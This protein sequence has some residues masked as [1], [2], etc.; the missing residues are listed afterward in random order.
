MYS[1]GLH[2]KDDQMI[3]VALN[4]GW[5]ET[6]LEGYE[7]LPLRDLKGEDRDEAITFNLERFLTR[8]KGGRDNLFI[9][10]SRDKVLV[11]YVYLPLAVEEN[12]RAALGYEM[13]RLTPFPA[14][15]V[16][17]D[18]Y[19]LKRLPAKNLLYL[20]LITVKKEVLDYYFNLLKKIGIRPRG[21]EISSTALF[22]SYKKDRSGAEKLLTTEWIQ[23]SRLMTLARNT[24]PQ[25]FPQPLK[26]SSTEEDQP[27]AVD[28]LIGY[29]NSHFELNIIS[30]GTL[31]YSRSLPVH[32]ADPGAAKD[33]HL[34][35]HLQEI[36]REVQ[37]GMLN[38][39]E[40]KNQELRIRF[41]LAGREMDDDY[42]K[43]CTELSSLDCSVMKDFAIT[44]DDATPR[45]MLPLLSVA[46]GLAL[47]GLRRVP[48]DINLI[49]AAL[50]PKRK[51]SKKKMAAF[52]FA[53]FLLFLAGGFIV[54]T[55]I[56][57]RAH[58]AELDLQLAELKL[59]AKAV[60]AMQ[61]EANKTEKYAVDLNQIKE[62]DISKLRILEELTR[63]IP[64][65]SWLTDFEYT[66]EDKKI[67]L[68]GYSTSASKLIPILEESKLFEK[69][70]FTSPITKGG[71]VKE[72]FK[73]EMA[74]EFAKK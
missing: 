74:L 37:K 41:F 70:K 32:P 30:D 67:I 34:D 11:H 57:R 8:H 27:A 45:T 64:D 46:I 72:N 65:D 9:G 1:I 47:K 58:I 39:P 16:Y 14:D 55:E 63:I 21:I 24:L 4:Q 42:A 44:I 40:G 49:P 2:I 29:M 59:Q 12:L 56:E 68:S 69:V 6:V 52:A 51:R 31:C 28:V 73:I 53:F 23:N 43:K 50:R 19:V 7:I 54:K 61:E 71:S 25:L 3:L 66:A 62:H 5:R 60:E 17:F 22:N 35:S 36:Q 38:V 20:M 15:A 13:D 10:L 33:H 48:L 18:Y 26:T